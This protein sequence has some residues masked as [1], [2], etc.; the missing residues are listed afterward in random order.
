MPF[1]RVLVRKCKRQKEFGIDIYIYIYIYIYGGGR[2]LCKG[3]TYPSRH[4]RSKWSRNLPWHVNS[5]SLICGMNRWPSGRVSAPVVVGSISS[6]GDHDV[7]CWWDLIRSKQLFS[8]PYVTWKCLPDFLVMV[9]LWYIYTKYYR[10]RVFLYTEIVFKWWELL[11]G[12]LHF[13][14]IREQK[15]GATASLWFSGIILNKFSFS[16][17]DCPA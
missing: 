8:A 13:W 14:Q 4:I 6:G 11:H 9:I 15:N 1:S 5:G 17:V 16:Q 10:R 12:Q 3:N 7:Y 2:V